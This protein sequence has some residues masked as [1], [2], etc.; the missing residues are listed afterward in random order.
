MTLFYDRLSLKTIEDLQKPPL[1]RM[2]YSQLFQVP[3]PLRRF[4]PPCHDLP[5]FPQILGCLPVGRSRRRH[6]SLPAPKRVPPA[7]DAASRPPVEIVPGEGGESVRLRFL[8]G[9]MCSP[10][11]YVCVNFRF[12]VVGVAFTFFKRII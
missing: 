10:E 7:D 1:S 9:H 12:T 11:A 8:K 5:R 6:P 3:V 4:F 2:L